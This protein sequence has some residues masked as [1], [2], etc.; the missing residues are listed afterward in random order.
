VKRKDKTYENE[1]LQERAE[2]NNGY[3]VSINVLPL[4]GD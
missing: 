1:Q 3:T 4:K 2:Q